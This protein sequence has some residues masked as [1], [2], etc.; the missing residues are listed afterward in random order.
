MKKISFL[1]LTVLG[2]TA[3]MAQQT[4]TPML[5]TPM[6]KVTRVGIR[7]GLNLADLR[8]KGTT[9]GYSEAQ[10]KTAF[11]GGL[12]LN[13]PLG[14][15]NFR[16][17]PELSYSS[18]G[19]KVQGPSGTTNNP[20]FEQDLDYIN[21]PLNFQLMTNN[22]FFVQTG[23][24]VGFLIGSEISGNG[25]N[26][27]GNKDNFDKFDLAWTA[28]VGYLSRIGLGLDLRY[29]YGIANIVADD[30]ASTAAFAGE[31]WKNGVAQFSLIYH[32]GASK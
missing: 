25:N 10:S 24:Q 27:I 31:T 26:N 4:T 32:F 7:G 11:N 6:A 20:P 12:F 3:V 18:Q 8:S 23:P 21:I 15:K 19:G 28:G 22:G 2:T 5:R 1:L 14:T 29:N 13:I 30:A 17:Q 9:S 16:F